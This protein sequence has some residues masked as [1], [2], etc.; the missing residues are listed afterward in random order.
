[1]TRR[2]CWGC[3]MACR[4]L[5]ITTHQHSDHWQALGDVVGATGATTYAGVHDVAGLPVRT[6][7]PVGD[8]DTRDRAD[9]DPPGRAHAGID[10]PAL[11]RPGRASAPVHRRL[12][13]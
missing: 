5:L 13:L 7:H 4:P 12:P 10:C 9:G 1:M 8:G 6:D 2:R 11:P 3:S